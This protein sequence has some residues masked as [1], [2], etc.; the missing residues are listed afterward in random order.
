MRFDVAPFVRSGAARAVVVVVVALTTGA[1]CGSFLTGDDT[2]ADEYAR[3][4]VNGGVCLSEV[5]VDAVAPLSSATRFRHLGYDAVVRDVV[6]ASGF[7]RY[8]DLV[9]DPEQITLLDATLAQM[10]AVDPA[11]LAGTNERLAFWVNAYNAIVLRDAAVAYASDAAFRVDD[12]DF[13]FFKRREHTV[14]GVIYSLNEIENGVIR[15]D[16]SHDDL[17]GLNDD[18]WAPFQARHDE[19]WGGEPVDPRVHF[20]LNCASR[21]C[22]GLSTR[23]YAT[24]TLEQSLEQNTRAFILDDSRGA[25]PDGISE[26]F[27]FYFADFDV[28]G[29]I[30]GFIG[31]YRSL[32][33][34]EFDVT[35]FY[36]WSL[37]RESP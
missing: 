13:A 11:R 3:F 25:G 14:G 36:D 32:D 26:L 4:K 17:S 12:D 23:A 30:D 10:A 24:D 6:A 5:P 33:T 15:G 2:L 8:D 28:A 22:P 31:R 35:L 29:G 7:V 34:V 27:F 16:R 1:G 20:V 21:S 9:T 19:L 18:E 37:N